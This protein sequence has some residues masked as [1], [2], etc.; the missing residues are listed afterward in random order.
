MGM[1][2]S[3][4]NH[5]SIRFYLIECIAINLT[6]SISTLMMLALLSCLPDMMASEPDRPEGGGGRGR[7]LVVI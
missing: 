6:L 7:L 4:S 3:N 1:M 5:T 2:V